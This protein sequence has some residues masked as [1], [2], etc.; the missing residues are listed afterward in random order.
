SGYEQQG[1]LVEGVIDQILEIPDFDWMMEPPTTIS[2]IDFF[3]FDINGIAIN[4][5]Q[6]PYNFPEFR[7]AINYAIDKYEFLDIM[8]GGIGYPLD[9]LIPT[10]NPPWHN[11]DVEGT[12]YESDIP[13]AIAELES[14]GFI[15]LDGDGYREAPNGDPFTFRPAFQNVGTNWQAAWQSAQDEL[16]KAGIR[17]ETMP[18]DFNNYLD[19]MYQIPR[20]YEAISY[21]FS[22]GP[23]PLFLDQ[24]RTE[25]ILEP[26][27]NVWN[28]SNETF[29]DTLDNMLAATT[30]EDAIEYA[31]EAQQILV[32]NLP[33]I[34]LF[35]NLNFHV[36]RNDHLE[37]WIN[38]P[39]YGIGLGN[40][41]TP[42]KVRLIA[43]QPG[44][45]PATGCGGTYT[46]SMRQDIETQ[47]PLIATDDYSEFVLSQIYTS[48]VGDPNPIDLEYTPYG[49]GLASGWTQTLISTPS[50]HW[51][52]T[53]TLHENAT[54]H[55]GVPVTADDVVF[56][57]N[58][59]HDNEIP[60]YNSNF[61]YFDSIEKLGDYMVRIIAT[62]DSYWTWEY[63]NNW[64]ILPEHIWEGILYPED[65]TNPYPIGC[66]PFKWGQRVTN[67]YVELQSWEAYHRSF[68]TYVID[69]DHIP[70]LSFSVAIV[71]ITITLCVIYLCSGRRTSADSKI[72]TSTKSES[73]RPRKLLTEST[74]CPICNARL[75]GDETFCPGCAIRL[76]PNE[77]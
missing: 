29:D 33:F 56:S 57:Y 53:F 15:D 63:L 30:Y 75:Y 24:F 11:P 2:A 71:A 43:G 38:I 62:S 19:Q 17:M 36:Y 66:G 54:W 26:Y 13:A 76:N 21:G 35:V 14:A 4:C 69:G 58:Y 7:R 8:W 61:E 18:I 44:R 41:W 67:E 9:S 45:D 42:L 23:N 16:V 3:N 32:E 49:N 25:L 72:R 65:F 77:D 47:N 51:E 6:Y 39:G 73:P 27:G 40:H 46:A 68:H 22:T 37:G 60:T 12:F 59:I 48:L 74:T 55:D 1:A 20:S 50:P 64:T 28:W 10:N 52:F 70:L 5:Q 31:H 34:P